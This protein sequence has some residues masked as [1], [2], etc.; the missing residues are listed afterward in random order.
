MKNIEAICSFRGNAER[1]DIYDEN[2]KRLAP[3]LPKS[4]IL[5][6]ADA[7]DD[8]T[9]SKNFAMI[10]QYFAG[11]VIDYQR[12]SAFFLRSWITLLE[13]CQSEYVLSIFEDQHMFGITESLLNNVVQMM[14]ETGVSVFN[15]DFHKV[16]RLDHAEKVA[17]LYNTTPDLSSKCELTV[18]KENHTFGVINNDMAQQNYWYYTNNAVYRK[19]ILIEQLKFFMNMNPG[20]HGVHAS[21]MEHRQCPPHLRHNKIS[22]VLGTQI[23]Y[24]DFD[25]KH[26]IGIR[27]HPI[28][29]EEFSAIKNGYTLIIE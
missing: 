26:I 2:F 11:H 23:G 27:E 22:V 12:D 20:I 15:F 4:L 13:S 16:R 18:N 5:H 21:E 17:L 14:D 3:Q 10:N 24:V 7:S 9:S 6:I 28:S 1:F 19:S 29:Q 25:Y 8:E